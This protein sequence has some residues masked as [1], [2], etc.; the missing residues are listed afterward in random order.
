MTYLCFYVDAFAQAGIYY[1][2]QN[3]RPSHGSYTAAELFDILG[4]IYS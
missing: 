2:A 1:S 4:D 3:E